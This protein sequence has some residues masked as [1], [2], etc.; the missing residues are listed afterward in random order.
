MPLRKLGMDEAYAVPNFELA[1]EL[2]PVALTGHG[3]PSANISRMKTG[4]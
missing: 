4:L 2:M 3:L 1:E